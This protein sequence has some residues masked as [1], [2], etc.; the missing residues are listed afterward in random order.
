[1]PKLD[2]KKEYRELFS[3][4]AKNPKIHEIPKMNY[5]S[6]PGSGNPNTS[7]EFS[8]A[9]EALYSVAYTAKFSLKKED[10]DLDFVVPPLEG[11]WWT[12]D[13][14]E[15]SMNRKE[16]W[17]WE[18]LIMIPDHINRD[19]IRKTIEEVKEKK[20]PIALDKLRF[21]EFEEGLSCQIMHIGPYDAEP[22][23]IEKLHNFIKV[24]GYEL[25]DKHHEIYL[26]DPRRCAPE[27]MKTII[28]QPIC[29]I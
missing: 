3:A 12:N 20:N 4:S 14:N 13:M 9:I 2:L 10:A 6:V 29:K 23:T 5:L 22:K 19:I 15:F 11:L 21:V 24:N 7:E 18:L 27:K 16:D 8:N 25:R 26:S 1:M 28:R 17:L